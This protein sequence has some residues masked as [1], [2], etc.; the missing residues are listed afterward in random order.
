M[1]NW[2]KIA[3]YYYISTWVPVLRKEGLRSCLFPSRSSKHFNCINAIYFRVLATLFVVINLVGQL[4]SVAMVLTRF[5]VDI[6]CCVLFF[7][8]V[9]QVCQRQCCGSGSG[10]R[11][12]FDPGPGS[13]IGFFWIPDPNPIFFRA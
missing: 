2:E 11:C 4:G 10:I 5:K 12:L 13:G 8:V 3:I 9:L 6:A 7:I 1:S